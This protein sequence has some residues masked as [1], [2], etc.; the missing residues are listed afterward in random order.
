MDIERKKGNMKMIFVA[1]L[2]LIYQIPVDILGGYQD[3]FILI[4]TVFNPFR[5]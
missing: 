5:K 1:S 2:Y 3:Y 4:I